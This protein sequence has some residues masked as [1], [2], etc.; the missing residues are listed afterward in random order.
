MSRGVTQRGRFLA[1]P[2]GEMLFAE[3]GS[4]FV[5][6]GAAAAAP[7]PL[8]ER[9][10]FHPFFAIMQLLA[11]VLIAACLV[12][13]CIG[14]VSFG[15]VASNQMEFLHSV[16]PR[17]M[18]NASVELGDGRLAYLSGDGALGAADEAERAAIAARVD[19]VLAGLDRRFVAALDRT[20][21]LNLYML[22]LALMR[23]DQ[24]LYTAQ[25]V[26][27]QLEGLLAQ[28]ATVDVSEAGTL[29]ALAQLLARDAT[30]L[31]LDAN[32]FLDQIRNG[33]AALP[34]KIVG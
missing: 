5:D 10:V 4:H 1:A 31:T 13:I 20:T 12:A 26:F 6:A 7:V 23:V 14:A 19:F 18:A 17:L 25:S 21:K 22:G 27:E 2:H 30:V 8:A 15:T 32:D 11:L 34:I 33:T 16:I 3:P 9:L 24:I 29:L 28:A